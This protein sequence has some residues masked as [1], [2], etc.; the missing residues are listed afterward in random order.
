MLIS[1]GYLLEDEPGLS[2]GE[3]LTVNFCQ[4]R[5]LVIHWFRYDLQLTATRY[6]EYV[7]YAGFRH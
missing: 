2:M 4:P 3:M 6:L 1:I 7:V 5:V